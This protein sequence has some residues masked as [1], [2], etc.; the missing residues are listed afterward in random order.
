MKKQHALVLILLLLLA[1][2]TR[3]IAQ[4]ADDLLISG[5][6]KS[7]S[8]DQA[9]AIADYTKSIAI[10]P[11]IETYYNRALAYMQSSKYTEAIA[12]FDKVAEEKKD[13]AVF[14]FLR[15]SCKSILKD[16]KNAI[17]DFDKAIALNPNYGKAYFSRGISKSSSND[18]EGAC[19]DLKKSVDLKYLKAEDI[20]KKVCQ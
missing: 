9:G 15:G 4:T 3:I 10:M 11:N 6:K 1:I 5:L 16:Y 7:K 20:Y 19:R 12:D 14:F 17:I 2:P 13:I 8:N 18:K